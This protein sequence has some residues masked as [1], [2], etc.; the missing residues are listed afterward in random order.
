MAD[1]TQTILV[2]DSN[3]RTRA[4]LTKKLAST[5]CTV[6]QA[7]DG[8]RAFEIVQ[9]GPVELLVSELYLQTGEDDCLIQAMRRNRVRGTRL[10]AHTVHAKAIDREW[11]K[12]WGANAYLIQPAKTERLK[13]VVSRLLAPRKAPSTA[14]AARIT[15]RATLDDAFAEIESGKLHGATSVVFAR[16][17]WTGLTRSQRNDYRAHAKRL[18]VSLRADPVMSQRFVELR[19]T[20]PERPAKPAGKESPYRS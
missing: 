15:R 14:T 16:S 3:A 20:R 10:L 18:E 17:W 2:V 6:L 12:R 9:N 11:A 1:A 13:Y 4:T 7:E 5:G 8:A 19:R